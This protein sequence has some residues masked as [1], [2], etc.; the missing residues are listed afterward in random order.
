MS[1]GEET[2]ANVALSDVSDNEEIDDNMALSGA[3]IVSTVLDVPSNKAMGN[4]IP[5]LMPDGKKGGSDLRNL[6]SANFSSDSLSGNQS[7]YLNNGFTPMSPVGSNTNNGGLLSP[8]QVATNYHFRRYSNSSIN[9]SPAPQ[10]MYNSRPRPKSGMFTMDT[11]HYTISEDDHMPL[12]PV[13]NVTDYRTSLSANGSQSYLSKSPSRS[14]SPTRA[15]RSV[16]SKS[17]VRR[18]GS[19]TKAQ[20][21]NFKP[22][23]MFLNPNGSSHSISSK[24]AQRKGHRY[25]TSSVS[26]NL[27]QEPPPAFTSDAVTIPDSYPIPTFKESIAYIKGNQKLRLIWSLF[28]FVTALVVF[29]IGF[30]YKLSSLSTLAHLIFYDSLGSS[31]IVFVDIMSNFEVWNKSS[32]TYPFGLGR[33]EVLAGFAL[34]SSLIMVGFDLLS[35]FIEEFMA[36]LVVDDPETVEHSSHHV[37]GDHGSEVNWFVYN[38]TLIAV[39]GITLIS[40]SYILAYDKINDMIS[41]SDD[42][43]TSKSSISIEEKYDKNTN[44]KLYK[45]LRIW[46]KNPTHFLTLC[47]SLYLFISPLVPDGALEAVSFDLNELATLVVASMLS[48]TGWKLVKSL[49]GIL[50]CSYPYSDYDYRVLKSVV[51][52]RILSSDAYKFTY[53]IDSLFVTKFN[54]ELFVVGVRITMKGA[55]VD[56]ES[57][58]RFQINKIIKEEIHTLDLSGSRNEIEI[59]VDIN[60]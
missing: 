35:H 1:E 55:D 47:Y 48:Y 22:Q 52:D 4:G 46:T 60:R 53:S 17:P 44:S 29:I 56:E 42:I 38:F 21:F 19:P 37:H 50:L 41:S 12:S 13:I 20:P 9:G 34:S 5:L 7:P 2:Y 57:R 16:R 36:L 31:V 30:R 43:N 27:F 14:S 15:G 58:L 32:I 3:P 24:P 11:N 49:G 8:A 28:H 23:E 45:Y 39:I 18:S 25:K 26:M 59:T 6:A 10:P 54:Y 33:V 51:T 40:S